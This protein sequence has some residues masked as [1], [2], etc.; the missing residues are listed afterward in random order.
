MRVPYADVGPR[1]VPDN[2][3]DEQVLFLTDI[4][5]TGWTGVDW[6]QMK[7]GETVVVFG[8]GPVG[9]MAMKSAWLQ[10]AGRV[11]GVDMLP[12]RLNLARESAQAEVINFKEVDAVEVIRSMTNGR[13]AD[14]VIDAVG[15]EADHTVFDSVSNIFHAQVGNINALKM[16]CSAVRRNGK[17]SLL[18]VYGMPYDNFPIGQLFDKGVHLFMG[19]AP[20]QKYID[21]LMNLVSEGKVKLDDIITHRLPLEDAA[22]AYDIFNKKQDNCLKVVLKPFN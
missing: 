14:V 20:V 7:G 18:G 10:G 5:P 17:L 22:K 2:L 13:G 8:C 6:A 11:I 1:K 9:I 12:Y 4:F 19:Q 21:H 16:C 15:M 3:S